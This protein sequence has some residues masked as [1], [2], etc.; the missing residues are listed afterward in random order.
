MFYNATISPVINYACVT[1]YDLL[2]MYLKHVLDKPRRTCGKLLVN[3]NTVNIYNLFE[4]IQIY[5]NS[6][7]RFGKSIMKDLSHPLN[8]EFEMLPSGR[9]LRVCRSSTNRYKFS[10]V[11]RATILINGKLNIM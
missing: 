11:P 8:G 10:F 3:A 2:T 6:L 1:F 4:N 9:R 5:D 7:Y